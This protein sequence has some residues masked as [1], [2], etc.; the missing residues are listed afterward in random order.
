LS[1][2]VSGALLDYQGP[3][4]AVLDTVVTYERGDFEAPIVLSHRD[5][6]SGAY[7][8]SLSWAQRT[9]AETT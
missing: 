6:L 9:L 2:A 8:A 4:G 5:G 3:A 7:R 1:E